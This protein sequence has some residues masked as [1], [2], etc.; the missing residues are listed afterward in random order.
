MVVFLLGGGQPAAI[1]TS[2]TAGL[3]LLAL[4]VALGGVV[5]LRRLA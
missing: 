5:L 3:G 1:P 2:T 4:L